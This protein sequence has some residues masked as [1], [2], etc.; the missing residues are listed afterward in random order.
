M[1]REAARAGKPEAPQQGAIRVSVAR[2]SAEA[3]PERPAAQR[4][5]RDNGSTFVET[6]GH[7]SVRAL[8]RRPPVSGVRN[9]AHISQSTVVK[10]GVHLRSC[11]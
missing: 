9:P 4:Q 8:S 2:P 3:W 6:T 7:L 1:W 10:S 5:E 11:R